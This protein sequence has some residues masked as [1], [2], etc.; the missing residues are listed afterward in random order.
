[1]SVSG[2]AGLDLS[3]RKMPGKVQVLNCSGNEEPVMAFEP[4]S[5][6]SDTQCFQI[7]FT[8]C[9]RQCGWRLEFPCLSFLPQ[10]VGGS[11]RNRGTTIL[12]AAGSLPW[13]METQIPR[14]WHTVMQFES[15]GLAGAIFS[16]SSRDAAA[17]EFQQGSDRPE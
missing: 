6:R 11:G 15:T 10:F 16:A 8:R 1:M 12:W 3:Q 5:W 13:Q 14:F 4:I 7:R 17:G 9:R 2:G